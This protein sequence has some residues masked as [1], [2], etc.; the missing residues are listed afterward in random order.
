MI[1]V[2]LATVVTLLTKPTYEANA[3][4]E[5]NKS[6]SSL[7]LGLGDMLSQGL[8]G[9]AD[10]LLTDLQTETAILQS[11]SLAMAVIEH[12]IWPR[13]L[14]LQLRVERLAKRCRRRA[15][16]SN[17]HSARGRGL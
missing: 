8:S 2:V 1:C 4:I 17:E 15:Y 16:R 7:D 3:T 11:D 13:S 9:G 5:L 12:L 14:S 6:T 10:T